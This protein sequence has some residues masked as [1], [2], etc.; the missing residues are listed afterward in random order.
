MLTNFAVPNTPSPIA[1]AQTQV[2]TEITSFD[3]SLPSLAELR[4]FVKAIARKE[5]Q[6]ETVNYQEVVQSDFTSAKVNE[7]WGDL[8]INF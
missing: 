4:A 1:S 5:R 3:Y 2:P 6:N 7:I 8:V